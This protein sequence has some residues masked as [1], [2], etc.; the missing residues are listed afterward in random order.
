MKAFASAFD[1]SSRAAAALGTVDEQ[2]ARAAGVGEAGH[3]RRL[4]ADHHQV[5]ARASRAASAKASTSA[6]SGSGAPPAVPAL[7][8]PPAPRHARRAAERPREGVLAPAA[9]HDQDRRGA[10]GRTSPRS[11]RRTASG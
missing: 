10:H 8:G 6:G 4:G 1:A 11:T 7:P 2:A 3:Q 5:D 9:A